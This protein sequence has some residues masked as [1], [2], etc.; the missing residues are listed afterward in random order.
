[1]D[2][3]EEIIKRIAPN[4]YE[5]ISNLEQA[6]DFIRDDIKELKDDIS[7]LQNQ[8]MELSKIFSGL[9]GRYENIEDT[10]ITKI[11]NEFQQALIVKLKDSLE[12]K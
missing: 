12:K 3:E 10:V 11:K 1:M 6:I 5:K 9:K 2:L 8:V 7:S 4:L